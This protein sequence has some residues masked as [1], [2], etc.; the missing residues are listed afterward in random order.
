MSDS[1][2]A[3]DLALGAAFAP[4]ERAAWQALVARALGDRDFDATLVTRTYEG[5]DLQPLYGRAD[6]RP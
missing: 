6:A 1:S 2:V 4:A 3:G 5:L